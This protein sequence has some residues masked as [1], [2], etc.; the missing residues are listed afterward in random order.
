V[1]PFNAARYLF[2]RCP[3]ARALLAL[4]AL[5]PVVTLHAEPPPAAPAPGGQMEAAKQVHSEY[6]EL[7]NRL[8][9]IQKKTMEAHPELQQQEKA[10]MDLMMTKMTSADGNAKDDLAAIEKLEQQLRSADTPAGDRQKLMGEYQQKATAFRTAQMQAFKDPEVQ[11]A[12]QALMTAT[13]T[14]MK[15]EDPRTEQIMQQLQQKQE[16]LK[17]LMESAGHGK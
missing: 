4:A 17:N 8:A 1:N 16:E 12:Q 5:T 7:Q 10:F 6:M 9:Q 3:T 2:A 13:V 11:K 14:A 15:K